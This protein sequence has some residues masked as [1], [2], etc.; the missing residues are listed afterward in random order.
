MFGYRTQLPH[1]SK[2][3]RSNSVCADN[4]IHLVSVGKR[5][6]ST[7]PSFIPDSFLAQAY[8]KPLL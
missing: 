4:P 6:V 7:L 2:S 1:I 8:L 3:M 5:S